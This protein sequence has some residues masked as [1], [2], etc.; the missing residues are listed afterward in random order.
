MLDVGTNNKKLLDNKN[1]RGLKKQRPRGQ[2]YDLFIEAFIY[3]VKNHAPNI[4]LHWEDF[5]SN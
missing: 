1:Y 5:S 2:D 4:F 3:C